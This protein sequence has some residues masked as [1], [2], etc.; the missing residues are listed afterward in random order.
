MAISITGL[1]Y[2]AVLRRLFELE[3]WALVADNV[4]H[5]I[6]P[7]LA[8]VVWLFYGPR[9]L[10]SRR[11]AGP[12]VLFPVAWLIFTLIRGELVGFYPYPF[13]DVASLGYAKDI[14]NCVW[15]SVL[16]LGVAAIATALDARLSRS[17]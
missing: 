13:V 15:V 4:V 14:V 1:V 10:T 5:T 9:G 7:I 16:Y 17:S 3:S 11:I 8:E 12:A 2:H 6:V